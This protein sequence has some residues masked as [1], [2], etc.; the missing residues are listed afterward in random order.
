MN[1][2]HRRAANRWLAESLG[3]I[4]TV[5]GSAA[6]NFGKK[7]Y[8]QI[9]NEMVRKGI[10]SVSRSRS[11]SRSRSR[12]SY[13]RSSS[14]R[15]KSTTSK[16]RKRR[17]KNVKVGVRRKK[18]KKN[19]SKCLSKCA[20]VEVKKL[21]AQSQK[22]THGTGYMKKIF[23]GYWNNYADNVVGTGGVYRTPWLFID[24]AA[25][26][27]AVSNV[28]GSEALFFSPAKIV[29]AASVLWNSKTPAYNHTLTTNNLALADLKILVIKSKVTYTMR[30]NS[31]WWV[32]IDFYEA[33]YKEN[34]ATSAFT[35]WNSLVATQGTAKDYISNLQTA[36]NAANLIG[37]EPGLVN[38]ISK[39]CTFKKRRI[40]LAPGQFKTI[41][42]K[43]P[44]NTWYDYNKFFAAD[45][46]TRVDSYAKNLSVSV[47]PMVWYEPYFSGITGTMEFPVT[48]E[49]T[50]AWTSSDKQN[51]VIFR[52]QEDYTLQQPE[53]TATTGTA[54]RRAV[55]NYI[56][57]RPNNGVAGKFDHT[58]MDTLFAAQPAT[59][60]N[61]SG[62][63]TTNVVGTAASF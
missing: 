43:G 52:Y 62:G 35:T 38:G 37:C 16:G 42:I 29:D 9:V 50:T 8:N 17:S 60:I 18:L 12:P 27:V 53:N 56:P 54:V 25:N 46:T 45:G 57:T 24:G 48:S 55:C 2:E 5:A 23:G 63:T 59:V 28:A 33:S 34:T 22:M 3:S 7:V 47:I 30:N 31:Q 61:G 1:Q 58:N 51:G 15:R 36:T 39:H 32:H 19:P 26:S 49:A 20:K 10:K 11:A 14:S 40:R 13:V 44:S 41:S 4:G 21:I 6:T